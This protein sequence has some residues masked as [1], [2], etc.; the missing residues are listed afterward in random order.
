MAEE[1]DSGDKTEEP[2]QHRIDEFRKKGQVA[3]SKELSSILILSACL[4]TIGLSVIFIYEEVATYMEWLY[5]QDFSKAFEEKIMQKILTKAVATM[6]FCAAPIF[7]VSFL[8]GIIS[9]VAQVG[10][11]F[12]PEVLE[13]KFNKINPVNG[14]KRLFSMKS[15][16]EAIK[17]I[18]KFSVILSITFYVLKDKILSFAGFLQ[19]SPQSGFI[20]GKDLILEAGFLIILGLFI[21]SIAD[22]AFEKFQY[23]QKLKQ[24]KKQ[25]KEETKEKE[26]NPEI[27]Q[28]I[29]SIQREMATKRMMEQVPKADVIVTNP[30]HISIAIKYDAKTM[31]AP[32]VIGKG[33]DNMAFRIREIAKENDI[34]MVENVK[35]ARALYKTVKV[36]QGVPR[37]LYKAV[38]EVLAFVYKMKRR[39]KALAGATIVQAKN[40]NNKPTVRV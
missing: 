12:A 34:P 11:L 4:L 21:I 14:F 1:N 37:D 16:F 29:R 18:F 22:F 31:I 39:K 25:I 9:N 17:G 10:L 5:L 36:G 40:N 35:L 15:I 6:L 3:S 23:Q 8:I 26:G 30:T 38:A 27:K 28:R 32:E 20:Y 19:T 13:I 24:T 33:A 2:T 7:L